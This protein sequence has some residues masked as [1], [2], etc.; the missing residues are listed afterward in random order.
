MDEIRFVSCKPKTP[1]HL[2]AN[3]HKNQASSSQHEG[4]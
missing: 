1:V 3:P 4:A 2:N